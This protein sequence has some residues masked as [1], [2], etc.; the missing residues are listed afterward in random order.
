MELESNIVE[1][2]LKREVR[3]EVGIEVDN[4]QFLASRSF[5]RS[6][7]HHVVALSFVVDYQSGEARPLEDQ[8]EVRW[9]TIAEMKN[10]FDD[11]WKD[12]LVALGN[13]ENKYLVV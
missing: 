2:S 13:F 12:I 3:E 9:V 6:S 7:G 10:L 4:F 1:K 5:I 8:D 11:H